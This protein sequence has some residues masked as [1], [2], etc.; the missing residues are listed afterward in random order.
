MLEPNPLT[1]SIDII[2]RPPGRAWSISLLSGGER[3]MTTVALLLA[4]FKSKP[5][6]FCILDE[7]DAALMN[8]RG[9]FNAV[10]G[11]PVSVSIRSHHASQALMHAPMFYM[12]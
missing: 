4:V 12:A 10:C 1:C 6:P 8:R 11:V 7:V 2:A 5:S 9:S 3:N